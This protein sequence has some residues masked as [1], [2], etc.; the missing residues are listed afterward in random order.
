MTACD[1]IRSVSMIM[2]CPREVAQSKH[3]RNREDGLMAKLGGIWNE[4]KRIKRYM[5]CR[6]VGNLAKEK[7]FLG[8]NKELRH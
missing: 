7:L 2:N 3:K 5:N 8:S 6:A 1:A 4:P